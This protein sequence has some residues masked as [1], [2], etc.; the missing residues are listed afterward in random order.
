MSKKEGVIII[1]KY[2]AVV[3]TND[4]VFKKIFGQ[5]GNESIT[6]SFINSILET[7]IQSVNLE[8]NTI[9]EKDLLDEKVGIL[10][11]KA[12]LDDEIMCDIEMQIL[13]HKDIDK[14]IMFYWSKL[15]SSNIKSGQN[16]NFLKKTISILIANFEMENL[17]E[18]PKGHTEWKI[19]EKNFSKIVLTNVFELHII[20]IP[21]IKRQLKKIKVCEEEKELATWIKFLTNPEELGELDMGEN[22]ELKKAKE[23]FE[24]MQNDE[25]EQRMAELRMKHIMDTK[26]IEEYGYD[27]GLEEGLKRGIEQGIEQGLKQGIETG[28]EQGEKNAKLEI[29]KKLLNE[30]I[31]TQKIAELINISKD[32]IESI[33]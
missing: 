20:E 12:K 32:E 2:N 33:K 29:A 4:Y 5:V 24:N 16:Y 25:Y 15:Y 9:L 18:L 7:K 22:E 14:R 1:E 30:G 17:K 3:P 10:D 28:L 26:A 21:K 19:R 27:R 11:I 31:S 8:G 23:E 6:K 13:N